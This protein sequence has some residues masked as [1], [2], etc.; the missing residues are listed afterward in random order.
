MAKCYK[1]KKTSKL[2]KQLK[3]FWAKF[4]IIEGQ[5][6]KNIQ[7]LEG[8]MAK[9]TGIKDIEFFKSDI[10]WCGIGNVSR[11]MPLIQQEELR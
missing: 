5:F 9:A 3:P 4:E 1:I 2:I 8:Y 6:Y 11:T 7:A 10:E